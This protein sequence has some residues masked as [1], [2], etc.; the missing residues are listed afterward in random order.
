MILLLRPGIA[1]ARAPRALD[2][3]Q[4]LG[5][6]PEDEAIRNGV[7]ALLDQIERLQAGVI[8]RVLQYI[9]R[10]QRFVH[11]IGQM[12]VVPRSIS[13]PPTQEFVEPWST[14]SVA[15]P[16]PAVGISFLSPYSGCSAVRIGAFPRPKSSS[17]HF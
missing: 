11:Y 3:L 10:T 5:Y 8:G 2:A 17:E 14:G 9:R 1:A 12:P 7:A 13:L 6:G 4:S 15:Q 16:N